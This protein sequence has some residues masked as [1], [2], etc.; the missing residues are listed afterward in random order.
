LLKSVKSHLKLV[1][2]AI[3]VGDG[4]ASWRAKALK[5]SKERAAAS[6]TSVEQQFRQNVSGEC[7]CPVAWGRG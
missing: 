2:Q 7:S 3:V 1:S 5:R 4:G 6:G